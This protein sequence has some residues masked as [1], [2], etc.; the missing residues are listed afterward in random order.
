M[1]A[2]VRRKLKEETT[3]PLADYLCPICLCNYDQAKGLG[4]V[5]VGAWCL[6]HDH[7]TCK[8][9]GWL[10]HNCN[11][12]LGFLGDDPEKLRRAAEYLEKF[13]KDG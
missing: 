9:R 5:K 2:K 13:S 3:P 6:D 8:A 11:K 7:D 4:G 12:G 10:C 1:L